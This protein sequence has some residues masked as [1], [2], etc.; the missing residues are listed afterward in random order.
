MLSTIHYAY[1]VLLNQP[2]PTAMRWD[3]RVEAASDMEALVKQQQ[4]QLV[5]R[6]PQSEA[7][8]P[9]TSLANSRSQHPVLKSASRPEV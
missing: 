4:Q 5:V 1:N 3:T 6:P 2:S 7:S 8:T 9:R